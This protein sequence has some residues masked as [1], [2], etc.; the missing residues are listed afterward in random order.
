MK[1]RKICRENPFSFA[2]LCW[3]CPSNKSILLNIGYTWFSRMWQAAVEATATR[4]TVPFLEHLKQFSCWINKSPLLLEMI[5][6]YGPFSWRCHSEMGYFVTC[7]GRRI[8]YY[9]KVFSFS[10]FYF[11][12]ST[13]RFFFAVFFVQHKNHGKYLTNIASMCR[14]FLYMSNF[15]EKQFISYRFDCYC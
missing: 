13:S 14:P 1:W 2:I 10:H 5:F 12:H 9:Q 8:D 11:L 6:F 3:P 7:C 4:Y 15:T